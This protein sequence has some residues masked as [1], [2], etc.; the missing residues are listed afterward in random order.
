[1][2]EVIKLRR[3]DEPEFF[4]EYG[5][6]DDVAYFERADYEAWKKEHGD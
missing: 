3:E 1:M 5:I 4:E 2:Y 6:E